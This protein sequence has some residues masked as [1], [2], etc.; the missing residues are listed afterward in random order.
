MSIAERMTAEAE[1]KAAAALGEPVVVVAFVNRVS[2]VK[3]IA[4]N[5]LADVGTNLLFGDSAGRVGYP[6][7]EIRR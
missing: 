1:G 7:D 4:A 5:T 2:T 6:K 3:T